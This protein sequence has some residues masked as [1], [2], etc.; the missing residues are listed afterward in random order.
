MVR[1]FENKQALKG[2][3]GNLWEQESWKAI[4][5]LVAQIL[6]GS[7]VLRILKKEGGETSPHL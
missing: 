5:F 2:I 4:F 6:S 3:N 7:A 1:K